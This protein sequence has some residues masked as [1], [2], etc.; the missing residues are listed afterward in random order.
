MK[1]INKECRFKN[2]QKNKNNFNYFEKEKKD[3]DT[4]PSNLCEILSSDDSNEKCDENNN[5]FI[6]VELISYICGNS[7]IISFYPST[8]KN[9]LG[10]NKYLYH[11]YKKKKTKLYLCLNKKNN[12][13]YIYEV[14]CKYT[15]KKNDTYE[16]IK[17]NIN[18]DK[19][20]NSIETNGNYI[21]K[22]E[23]S[24]NTNSVNDED[25]NFINELSPPRKDIH[26]NNKLKEKKIKIENSTNIS[27]KIFV[28]KLFDSINF[29]YD[30]STIEYTKLSNT[31]DKT[32]SC[33]K[34]IL[35]KKIYKNPEKTKEDKKSKCHI[36]YM[37][38]NSFIQCDDLNMQHSFDEDN[39]FHSKINLKKNSLINI[40]NI[41]NN[42]INNT[43]NDDEI[44]ILF[45]HFHEPA[46]IFMNQFANIDQSKDENFMKQIKGFLN[47]E[48]YKIIER[49]Y[50]K[51]KKKNEYGSIIRKIKNEN[52]PCSFLENYES[53]ISICSNDLFFSDSEVITRECESDIK[54]NKK[55]SINI[56]TRNNLKVKWILLNL[57]LKNEEE[58][59][60]QKYVICKKSSIEKLKNSNFCYNNLDNILLKSR[61]KNLKKEENG[62]HIIKNNDILKNKK[63]QNNSNKQISDESKNDFVFEHLNKIHKYYH[64]ESKLKNKKKINDNNLIFNFH[65][66]ENVTDQIKRSNQK[67]EQ[68]DEKKTVKEEK[69]KEKKRKDEYNSKDGK[70]YCELERIKKNYNS[71]NEV[72]CYEYDKIKKNYIFENEKE[73][74]YKDKIYINNKAVDKENLFK[75]KMRTNDENN[76]KEENFHLYTDRN[77]STEKLLNKYSKNDIY[78]ND[79]LDKNNTKKRKINNVENYYDIQINDKKIMTEKKKKNTEGDIINVKNKKIDKREIIYSEENNTNNKNT[80]NKNKINILKNFFSDSEVKNNSEHFTYVKDD[81]VVENKYI[82]QDYIKEGN[83][84]KWENYYF[85]NNLNHGN[86]FNIHSNSNNS[87]NSNDD[88]NSNTNN[89]DKNN[90]GN[91]NNINDKTNKC[92]NNYDESNSNNNNIIKNYCNNKKVNNNNNDNNNNNNNKRNNKN[93]NNNNNININNENNNLNNNINNNNDNNNIIDDYINGDNKYDDIIDNNN[94][95]NNN[96]DNSRNKVFKMRCTQENMLKL[97][98]NHNE[99]KKN[100]ESNEFLNR[101]FLKY[102]VNTFYDIIKIIYCNYRHFRYTDKLKFYIT[103]FLNFSKIEKAKLQFMQKE[104]IIDTEILKYYINRKILEKKNVWKLN[105]YKIDNFNIFRLNKSKYIDDSIIDFFNNYIYSFILKFDKDKNDIYIFNTFFYKKIELYDDIFKAYINTNRWIKKLKKK[106]YEYKYVFIPINIKNTHW[107]L[108][109]L[110]FPFNNTQENI[111]RILEYKTEDYKCNKIIN[112]VGEQDGIFYM[113][114]ICKN[115]ESSKKNVNILIRDNDYYKGEIEN[116]HN[117]F[118]NKSNESFFFKKSKYNVFKNYFSFLNENDNEEYYYN[119]FQ[120]SLSDIGESSTMFSNDEF[121][122]KN[123]PN[124]FTDKIFLNKKKKLKIEKKNKNIKIAYMIYLD[125][126]LPSIKGNKILQKLK[127]YVEH[128]FILDQMTINK[129]EMKNKKTDI[130]E[131]FFKFIYPNI[132][133][134]QNN[135]YDCGIYIIQFILHICLNKH[136]VEND[137]I[138]P[139]KQQIKS[140]LINQK[141]NFNFSNENLDNYAFSKP[142]INKSIPW[143]GQKD[144]SIK[145]KQMKKM[146]LYMKDV[147]NWKSDN[148]IEALN[149]LFLMNYNNEYKKNVTEVD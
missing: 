82:N 113:Q 44:K 41:E 101:F 143:F 37:N 137:L 115:K 70:S 97:R 75:D 20:N 136:I 34:N 109:L 12:E 124:R 114:N 135:S 147:I 85:K 27:K 2:D 83:Q 26:V 19:L 8:N 43:K 92:G 9:N 94:S 116:S 48:K 121:S 146:L 142:N 15:K 7:K 29:S 104:K 30:L 144:I 77:S 62:N 50:S 28:T 145:R 56:L 89:Y 32:L 71:E 4:F 120:K 6:I 18:I 88:G 110:Y 87:I 33:L 81:I 47:D 149:L 79:S 40:E 54:E 108:V 11:F 80:K 138:N 13:I 46:H 1:N 119:Q 100:N 3:K 78:E 55:K 141:F 91:N 31:D 65:L 17:G 68:A 118:R 117:K 111:D 72:K 45:L 129:K 35:E 105:N 134:K 39:D 69:D 126:L 24:Y 96:N 53:D 93:N 130:Q 60:I 10:Q 57:N 38:K 49:E 76:E 84:K 67:K 5:N 61:K 23:H 95:N 139:F 122:K 51:V 25:N 133:P 106:I 59:M 42:N 22:I 125:S 131:I 16:D 73:N 148:H 127:K 98:I 63:N 86:K 74:L 52:I 103:T 99:S 64:N 128:L 58:V 36:G 102:K 21:V 140:K 66:D 90:N 112:E 123:H 107:S 14:Q 132:I